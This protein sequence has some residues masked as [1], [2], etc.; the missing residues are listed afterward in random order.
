MSRVYALLVGINDYP[1]KV[2]KLEG[3]LNDVANVE[4]YLKQTFTDPAIVVLKDHDATSENVIEQFRSH[5]GRAGKDDIAL[6]HYCG[7]GANSTAA[8]ELKTF[9]LSGR[10]QGLVCINSR[11]GD[12]WDLA[13]KE[14]AHLIQELARDDPHIAI[15][16]DCCKSGSG[17]RSLEA[18]LGQAVRTTNGVPVPRPLESYLDGYFTTLLKQGKP[19][20]IPSSRHILLAA[21]DRTQTAKE[22][23]QTHR[24]IFTTNLFEVLRRSPEPP[25]YADLF[26]RSRAAVRRYIRENDKTPQDPQFETYA[27][28][29]AYAGFLGR[30]TTAGRRTYSVYFDADRW[31]ADVGAIQGVSTDPALPVTLALYP[32]EDA[33]RKAGTARAVR[34]GAQKSEVSLDFESDPAT[35]YEAE[36]TSLPAAP[37]MVAFEGDEALRVTLQTA[38][39]ADG[40][41]NVTLTETGSDDGYAFVRDGETLLLR[42][43]G[44]D[45]PI[46]SVELA[47]GKGWTGKAIHLLKHVAQ[48]EQSL[49]LQNPRPL[50]DPRQVDFVFAEKL[51]D[52][53]E[54]Q[55]SGP[56]LTLEYRQVDGSWRDVLGQLRLRNRTGQLMHFVLLHLSADDLGVQVIANDQ[57]APGE[58][59]MT[60]TVGTTDPSPDV[61]F[62][63]DGEKLQT[64]ERLKLIVST[65]RVDDFLLELEPLSDTRGFGSAKERPD[66][67][68]K[69]V[70]DDWFAKEMRVT[71]VR[72]LDQVGPAD[73]A[74]AAGRIVVKAH[75]TVTANLSLSAATH[76]TRDLESGPDF[77]RTLELRG[78]SLLNFAGE[79]GDGQN[80]LELTDISNSD[81]LKT[82]PI[83]VQLNV[84]LA[85]NEAI[86]PVVFDGKHVLLAGDTWRDEAG[87]TQVSID[88][89]PDIAV[90]RRSI[91]GALK[92]YFFKT[93]L[94]V[95]DVNR[96]RWVEF[97]PD[98]GFN[99]RDGDLAAKV[100]HASNI[101]LV[102]HGIIGDTENM[103]IGVQDCGLHAKFDL[104][105]SYDYENLATPIEQTARLMQDAL[106]AA[107][108]GRDDGKRLTLL[109]HSMGGLVSRWFIERDGGKDL[110]DHLVLC[111]TPSRGS[112]LGR[113]DG[114]RKILTVLANVGLN[115]V[116]AFAAPVLLLLS[117]SK[118]LTPTLEQMNPDSGFITSLNASADP[119]VRYSVLA[120]DIDSYKEPVDQFFEEMLTKA[121]RSFVFDLL[122][123]Q[124]ANDIA[125]GVESI[126]DVAGRESVARTNVPCHHLNY[127]TS[128]A[129]RQALA[130]VRWDA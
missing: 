54:Y 49:N 16:L 17:T 111:G 72:R 85:E 25:T 45:R 118:K 36:I 58:D 40:T 55:H 7:H 38:L 44:P 3:C 18:Q 10:D 37:L 126:L 113:V 5:L 74:V 56:E 21:S 124:K 103:L 125:V 92:M 104:V 99:Y 22:D 110:V 19:L 96:L 75:P 23:L 100:A 108:L 114:A 105:L 98:G 59:W 87:A 9:D 35:R 64:V 52:G 51:D 2:G 47:G 128:E 109:V 50:I 65:E 41:V 42:R 123:A 130:A 127:F 67:A 46:Q 26:V 31:R 60:L 30:A 57:V 61:Y 88:R 43:R 29:D 8:P 97:H 81:A 112:P 32:E 76:A 84:P 83:Q 95:A 11:D 39:D 20:A 90:D 28:F 93:Y 34:V 6:F 129:G 77:C 63:V 24:G 70:T 53:T 68:A 115:Y 122:F 66:Q 69:P 101:L 116:P 78:M 107:G 12:N 94:K 91:G 33:G 1:A 27:G 121:G 62:S 82:E 80:V 48:W 4:D 71:I 106:V 120:G 89:V 13:D 14:L 119:G 117:R 79:R 73:A 86:L 102:V 15:I